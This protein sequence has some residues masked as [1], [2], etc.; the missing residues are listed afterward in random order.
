MLVVFKIEDIKG[1]ENLIDRIEFSPSFVKKYKNLIR[2]EVINY[3]KK[4]NIKTEEI[5][6]E[7]VVEKDSKLY[8]LCEILNKFYVGTLIN[9]KEYILH[10]L[11]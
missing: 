4:R 7:I 10:S 2:T 9:N 5:L 3:L 6:D 8:I 1:K 11:H